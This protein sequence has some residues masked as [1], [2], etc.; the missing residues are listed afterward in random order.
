M[1][2]NPVYDDMPWDQI[3]ERYEKSPISLRALTA[4]YGFRSRT[5]LK[6]RIE[7]EGWVRRVR[8][9]P[10][11]TLTEALQADE[12][13][14]PS[15]HTVLREPALTPEQMGLPGE[16]TSMPGTSDDEIDQ[17]NEVLGELAERFDMQRTT[18]AG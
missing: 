7:S 6:R 17:L 12:P 10:R 5:T 18:A 1:P 2:P 14:D 8:P 15:V 3:R 11:V 9:G 13:L 16:G 4:E